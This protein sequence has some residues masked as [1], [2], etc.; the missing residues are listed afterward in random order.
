MRYL[1]HIVSWIMLMFFVTEYLGYKVS[2]VEFWVL[3]LL[4]TTVY[5]SGKEV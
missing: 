1:A 5:I 2:S 3:I 4:V